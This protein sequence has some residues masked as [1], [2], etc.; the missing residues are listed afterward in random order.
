VLWAEIPLVNTITNSTA[1]TANV[2]QQLTD[3]ML[4]QVGVL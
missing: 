4:R 2:R 3:A 1:F